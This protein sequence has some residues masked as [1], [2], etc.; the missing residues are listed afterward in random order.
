MEGEDR[1][2]RAGEDVIFELGVWGGGRH[3]IVLLEGDFGA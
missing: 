1:A 3:A 2:G